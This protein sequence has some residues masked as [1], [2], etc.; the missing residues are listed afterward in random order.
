MSYSDIGYNEATIYIKYS[1]FKT[2]I[3]IKQGYILIN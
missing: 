3:H 2:E 1:V